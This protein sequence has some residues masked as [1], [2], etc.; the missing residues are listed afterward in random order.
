MELRPCLGQGASRRARVGR[1]RSPAFLSILKLFGHRHHMEGSNG[2]L[3]INRVYP[4]PVRISGLR[5]NT[6]PPPNRLDSLTGP[7]PAL[8]HGRSFRALVPIQVVYS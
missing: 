5:S 3:C 2:V 8:Y 7:K 6:V 1:V 4:Q